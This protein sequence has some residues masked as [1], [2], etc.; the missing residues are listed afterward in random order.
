MSFAFNTSIKRA[1]S[2]MNSVEKTLPDGCALVQ[3]KLMRQVKGSIA[4]AE[5]SASGRELDQVLELKNR[6]NDV[7]RRMGAW[8]RFLFKCRL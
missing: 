1:K 3:R 5:G 2:V 6:F 4:C 8:Q 7:L